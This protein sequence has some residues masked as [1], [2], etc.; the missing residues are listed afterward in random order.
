MCAN[1]IKIKINAP[2]AVVGHKKSAFNNNYNFCFHITAF[3]CDYT[4]TKHDH[5]MTFMTII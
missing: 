4:E 3:T 1:Q 2:S 5:Y